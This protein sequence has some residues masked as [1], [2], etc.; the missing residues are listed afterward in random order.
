MK[1]CEYIE[2]EVFKIWDDLNVR[3]KHEK[4]DENEY[5]NFG[6]KILDYVNC[7]GYNKESTI[8]KIKNFLV[9]DRNLIPENIESAIGYPDLLAKEL[10]RLNLKDK[11]YVSIKAADKEITA[12]QM[13]ILEQLGNDIFNPELS[14]YKNLHQTP[15]GKGKTDYFKYKVMNAVSLNGPVWKFRPSLSYATGGAGQ[16]DFSLYN[17][18]DGKSHQMAATAVTHENPTDLNFE[19]DQIFRHFGIEQLFFIDNK[20]EILKRD[21]KMVSGKGQI[22]GKYSIW[23]EKYDRTEFEEFKKEWKIDQMEILGRNTVNGRGSLTEYS[24]RGGQRDLIRKRWSD[25]SENNLGTMTYSPEIHDDFKAKIK[26]F[27]EFLG[28]DGDKSMALCDYLTITV[29]KQSIPGNLNAKELEFLSQSFKLDAEIKGNSFSMNTIKRIFNDIIKNKS[30]KIPID[31]LSQES[32]FSGDNSQERQATILFLMAYKL[33]GGE[34]DLSNIVPKHLDN[35]DDSTKELIARLLDQDQYQSQLEDNKQLPGQ[36][37]YEAGIDVI[38]DESEDDEDS[39]SDFKRAVKKGFP[40]KT[41]LENE[42]IPEEIR[43]SL[44]K[45]IYPNVL[46]SSPNG[47]EILKSLIEMSEDTPEDLVEI[48][49]HETQGSDFLSKMKKIMDENPKPILKSPTNSSSKASIDWNNN[50]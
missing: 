40:I 37:L 6:S 1:E 39:I 48:V 23:S 20:D 29:K 34:L 19:T 22:K 17:H 27:A 45:E 14:R 11:I 10:L 26:Y 18:K 50:H 46:S 32:F 13:F 2:V 24:S 7:G 3:S 44:I 43:N 31:A 30:D 16:P 28:V 49:E 15:P 9:D 38:N 8:D 5:T 25:L 41:I 21:E 42:E 33:H 47:F 12:S 35:V 36:G 4:I